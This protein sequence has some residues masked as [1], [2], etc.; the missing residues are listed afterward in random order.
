MQKKTTPRVAIEW[1][2]AI[3]GLVRASQINLC[4]ILNEDDFLLSCHSRSSC[5]EMRLKNVFKVNFL[6]VKEAVCGHRFR[7]ATTRC[8]NTCGGLARE[9]IE[10]SQQ[11][12]IQPLVLQRHILHFVGHPLRYHRSLR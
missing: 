6:I 12:I 9:L 10:Q 8:R 1:T 11:A 2:C 3:H 4:G 7:V 5:F